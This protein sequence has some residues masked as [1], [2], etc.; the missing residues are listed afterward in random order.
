MAI[1]TQSDDPNNSFSFETNLDEFIPYIVIK[2]PKDIEGVE[3]VWEAATGLVKLSEH[4]DKDKQTLEYTELVTKAKHLKITFLV[5]QGSSKT[6][7]DDG[8]I[9][10]KLS[11]EDETIAK[12][13]SSK[14]IFAKYGAEITVDIEITAKEDTEFY[15]D[16]YA[17][18]NDD[19]FHGEYENVYCGRVKVTHKKTENLKDVFY[20]ISLM[21]ET[22]YRSNNFKFYKKNIKVMNS[23]FG[24]LELGRY[25]SSESKKIADDESNNFDGENIKFLAIFSHGYQNNIFG[26]SD[27]TINKSEIKAMFSFDFINFSKDCVIFL[28]A[29]N[30]GTGMGKSFAQKLAD[31]TNTKVV[32]MVDDGVAVVSE[33]TGSSASPKMIYG[34][35][36]G[37]LYNAK[38][39]EFK[40]GDSPKVIGKEVDIIKLVESLN[41]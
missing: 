14:N 16:F 10:P 9:E 15:L 39:Y 23:S 22:D 11:V 35:K 7:D 8:Y 38:F 21:K 28:G 2:N 5:Q 32:G 19:Y 37:N 34:P 13:T 25:L 27:D 36:Y 24:H 3:K 31:I 40:K 12:I 6:W 29:C 20:A 30:S 26:D 18:D 1:I 17:N 41:I 4:L 33:T